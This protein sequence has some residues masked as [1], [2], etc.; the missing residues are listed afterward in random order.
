MGVG[1]FMPSSYL[2][3]EDADPA[4]KDKPGHLVFTLGGSGFVGYG[5]C[6]SA[7]FEPGTDIIA[8][9]PAPGP[10]SMWWSTSSADKV[11]EDVKSVP[12][13]KI[14]AELIERHGDWKDPVINR[15]IRELKSEL[16]LTTWTTP[17]LPTWETDGLILVGD[18]AHGM[19]ENANPLF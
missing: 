18:A 9:P 13:E 1:G 19:S 4:A 10:R 15:I 3:K 14:Q 6:S 2:P 17:K 5:A 7:P 12:Q 11:P 8:N 16:F